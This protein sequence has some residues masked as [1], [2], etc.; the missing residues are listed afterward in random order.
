MPYKCK[1]FIVIV[2]YRVPGSPIDLFNHL[3]HV[4][5]SVELEGK[6]YILMGDLNCDLL[7]PNPHCYTVRLTDVCNNFHLEQII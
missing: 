3:E 4:L 2:W 5:H 7:S 6:D 1:P